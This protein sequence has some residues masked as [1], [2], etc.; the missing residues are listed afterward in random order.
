MKKVLLSLLWVVSTGILAQTSNIINWSDCD[1]NNT[2]VKLEHEAQWKG[3]NVSLADYFTQHIADKQ[4]AGIKSGR[5]LVGILIAEDG[6]ARCRSFAN[7][8]GV[9]LNAELFRTAVNAMPN[10]TPATNNGHPA[11]FLT[12]ILFT[13]R[14]GK[15]YL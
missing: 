14:E 10:W 11:R 13:I 7:L 4:L 1:M 5:V 15:F 3:N 12:N 6:K 8:T 9:E 2:F